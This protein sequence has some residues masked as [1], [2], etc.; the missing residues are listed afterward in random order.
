MAQAFLR[1][2]LQQSGQ[3]D[4]GFGTYPGPADHHH[5][6]TVPP[7]RPLGPL[8]AVTNGEL[9]RISMAL[10]CHSFNGPVNRSAGFRSTVGLPGTGLVLVG[11]FIDGQ[12][13]GHGVT[14]IELSLKSGEP[15]W[16]EMACV[17][18][19]IVLR[20]GVEMV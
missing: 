11:E 17:G 20:S 5:G 9:G 8:R 18:W 6:L 3:P 13:G 14:P 2:L 10:G 15:H 16:H 1:G 7:L 4:P 12:S 19:W